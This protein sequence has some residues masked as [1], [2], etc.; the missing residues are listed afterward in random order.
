MLLRK[1]KKKTLGRTLKKKTKITKNLER[2]QWSATKNGFEEA[3]SKIMPRELSR[4]S[5]GYETDGKECCT[6]CTQNK[7]PNLQVGAGSK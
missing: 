5:K 4:R 2:L 6:C 7:E 1:K 3:S